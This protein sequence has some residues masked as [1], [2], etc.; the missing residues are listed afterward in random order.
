[1]SSRGR[2]RPGGTDSA[3]PDVLGGVQRQ[4]SGGSAAV[5]VRVAG[6]ALVLAHLL[7]VAWIS[8]RPRD[9]SWVTAPNI[10]PPRRPPRRPRPRY[11]R[12]RP[13]DR[14]GTAAPRPARGAAA[15]GRR[16]S[17]GVRLGLAGPDDRRRG[18]CVARGGTSADRRTRSG[19]G[20]GLGPPEHRRGGARASPPRPGRTDL[21]AP[22]VGRGKR[23]LLRGYRARPGFPP[24]ADRGLSGCDP[25][26][27]Q[28]PDR[29]VD[30][31]PGPS[32]GGSMESSGAR[33]SGSRTDSEGA[34]H[35]RTDP[36]P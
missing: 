14:R 26:D 25:E 2:D 32:S 33:R 13:A 23:G 22:Q 36:P 35:G 16:A 17:P 24:G 3:V 30:R 27:Y 28:G 8:L 34:H 20:R 19:G 6:F 1:M 9:V 31:R 15:D 10:V 11:R 7:L 29:P 21:A 12:G 18:P 5:V 4:G